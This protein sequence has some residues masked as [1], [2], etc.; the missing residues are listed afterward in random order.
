MFLDVCSLTVGEMGIVTKRNEMFTPH[1]CKE[2]T[3]ALQSTRVDSLYN[4]RYTF[5]FMLQILF[6]W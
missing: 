3:Q 2:D 6:T 4:G 1:D 5:W